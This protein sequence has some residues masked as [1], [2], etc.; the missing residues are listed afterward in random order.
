MTP[1]P[2][3]P[4]RRLPLLACFAALVAAVSATPQTGA[5]PHRLA[6]RRAGA[7]D[8]ARRRRRRGL[9]RR[10]RRT[11]R[12]GE[13]PARA[14]GRP[15]PPGLLP[16]AVVADLE[17]AG[18]RAG[19]ERAALVDGLDADRRAAYLRGDRAAAPPVP[20]DGDGTHR[21]AAAGRADAPRRRP[22]RP[23]SARCSTPRSA[24]RADAR[25]RRSPPSTCG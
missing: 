9:L 7:G 8:A 2:S 6:R 4:L 20:A 25:R 12:R 16:A 11:D 13:R 3:S 15:R 22:A 10:L 21:R 17:R 5:G 1:R 18:D 24:I 19:P 14:R 23:T